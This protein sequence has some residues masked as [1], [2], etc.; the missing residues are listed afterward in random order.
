MLKSVFFT[1]F[2]KKVNLFFKLSYHSIL[3]KNFN[4]FF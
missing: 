3:D 4:N 1:L 2:N